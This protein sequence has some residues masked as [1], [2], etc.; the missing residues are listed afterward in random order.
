[1]ANP[2]LSKD[3]LES[4][5]DNEKPTNIKEGFFKAC[6]DLINY[7]N[8]CDSVLHEGFMEKRGKFLNKAKQRY[9]VIWKKSKVMQYTDTL[10]SHN[11]G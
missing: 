10:K 6:P 2:K 9:F 1:M 3:L 7:L 8:Y 11:L 5:V 4:E